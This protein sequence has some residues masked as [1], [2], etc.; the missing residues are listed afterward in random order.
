MQSVK[1]A[2]RHS[3]FC[4]LSSSNQHFPKACG[5]LQVDCWQSSQADTQHSPAF[6][7]PHNRESKTGRRQFSEYPKVTLHGSQ[8][9]SLYVDV[10][11]INDPKLNS[12]PQMTAKIIQSQNWE[13]LELPRA[14]RSHLNQRTPLPGESTGLSPFIQPRSSHIENV[15]PVV[16]LTRLNSSRPAWASAP[17][18]RQHLLNCPQQRTDSTAWFY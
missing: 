5:A 12:L 6:S 1:N 15:I 3:G 17:A 9:C 16:L 14:S 11:K 4:S 8:S 7:R 13:G 18:P 2:N 10:W